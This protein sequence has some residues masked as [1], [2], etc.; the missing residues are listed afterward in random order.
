ML[1][2]TYRGA[3]VIDGVRHDAE[4]RLDA[5]QMCLVIGDA[6]VLSWPISALDVDGNSGGYHVRFDDDEF[7]FEPSVDDGFGDELHLRRRLGHVSPNGTAAAVAPRIDIEPAPATPAKRAKRNKEH[8]R[9][10]SVPGRPVSPRSPGVLA[11]RDLRT[12]TAVVI[13]AVLAVAVVAVA[14]TTGALDREPAA[15]V[16][17]DPETPP[18]VPPTVAGVTVTAPP[19]T[20]AVTVPPTTAPPVT[21]T[22]PPPTTQPPPPETTVVSTPVTS[23]VTV[24]PSL[25]TFEMTGDEF[26]ARW[27]ELMLN[28]N[29]VLVP[30]E[31][32]SGEGGFRFTSGTFTRVDGSTDEAG[33]VRRVVMRGDPSGTTI[34]DR[35]ILTAMGVVIAITEPDLPPQGR[36]QLIE[37][38]G[39]DIDNPDV[40]SLDRSLTY[41]DNQYALKWDSTERLIVFDIQPAPEDD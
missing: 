26:I 11:G 19:A 25:S 4:V 17:A 1:P 35:N 7:R 24:G 40:A 31:V 32:A 38:L 22:P 37:A 28:L 21:T 8:L 6:E 12:R 41:R 27:H 18:A 10:T 9:K 3:A 23:M 5:A 2:T 14:L 34:D 33:K 36:R 39:L 29:S 13:L 16:V 30:A 15:V 20:T